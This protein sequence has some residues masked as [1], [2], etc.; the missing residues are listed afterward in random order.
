MGQC[1]MIVENDVLWAHR[2]KMFT[3]LTLDCAVSEQLLSFDGN[4]HL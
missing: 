4:D 1:T 3:L 2:K